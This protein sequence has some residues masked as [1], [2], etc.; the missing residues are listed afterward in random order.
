MWLHYLSVSG[1]ALLAQYKAS[2]TTIGFKQHIGADDALRT[3]AYSKSLT[4]T[5][6]AGTTRLTARCSS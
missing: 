5:R 3:G 2:A 1:P 6:H 4:F